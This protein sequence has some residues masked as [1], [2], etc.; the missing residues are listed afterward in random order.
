MKLLKN[1][2]A[3]IG[4]DGGNMRAKERQEERAKQV[5]ARRGKELMQ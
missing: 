3:R 1:I 5:A 4:I 2:L